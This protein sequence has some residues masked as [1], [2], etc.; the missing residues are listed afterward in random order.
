MSLSA[1]VTIVVPPLTDN[2][3]W[4][5]NADSWTNYWKQIT[6]TATFTPANNAI[7]IPSTYNNEL[8]PVILQLGGIDYTL[9]TME[10]FYS[11]KNKLD[12]LELSYRTLREEMKTMGLLENSQ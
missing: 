5:A 9:I 10:M 8:A 7:Y 12:T 3:V 11:M 4:F 2:Q 6:S 1:N